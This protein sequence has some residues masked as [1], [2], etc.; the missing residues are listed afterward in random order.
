MGSSAVLFGVR[1]NEDDRVW[2]FRLRDCAAIHLLANVCSALAPLSP[3]WIAQVLHED[4]E[5]EDRD[6]EISLLTFLSVDLLERD[7]LRGR[8]PDLPGDAS[9][10]IVVDVDANAVDFYLPGEVLK[11]VERQ[12]LS[13]DLNHVMSIK[14][15]DLVAWVGRCNLAL[16]EY[17]RAADASGFMDGN[18]DAVTDR[19]LHY[20]FKTTIL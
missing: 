19:A 11:P 14:W 2:A 10:G 13:A 18:E 20:W 6:L 1:E 3:S 5:A 8:R 7:P 4:L 12:P 9:A 15:P 16:D 17:Q